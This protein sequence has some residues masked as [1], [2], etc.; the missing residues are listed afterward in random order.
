LFAACGD[1]GA[2]DDGSSGATTTSETGRTSTTTGADAGGESVFT[3]PG[4]PIAAA[5]GETFVIEVPYNA[6]TGYRNE[7]TTEPDPA[8]A[9][10]VGSETVAPNSDLVG[11][12]GSERYT[13][14]AVA[15]GSTTM[16]ITS[17]PPGQSAD[18]GEATTFT[19]D[20]S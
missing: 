1:D 20:V 13:L 17:I 16:V 7:V 5:P 15:A 14:R 6:S 9:T 3:D 11:A 2:H 10:L 12:G 8:V 18:A 19:I 4:T